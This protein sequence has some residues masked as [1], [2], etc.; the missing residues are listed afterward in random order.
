[1]EKQGLRSHY[2]TFDE[3]LTKAKEKL[4]WLEQINRNRKALDQLAEIVRL[5]SLYTDADAW[6]WK[7][8]GKR[9]RM[10]KAP[11]VL[12]LA[13]VGVKSHEEARIDLYTVMDA[14]KCQALTFAPSSMF[15]EHRPETIYSGVGKLGRLKVRL[16][17]RGSYVPPR[18]SVSVVVPSR[19]TW[20]RTP[21]TYSVYCVR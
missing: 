19:R 21:A 18:C 17:I 9:T 12:K 1:M 5:D 8:W 13:L 10:V 16:Q 14:L 7:R 4:A 15:S 11:P 3:D 6:Q 2:F 20:S